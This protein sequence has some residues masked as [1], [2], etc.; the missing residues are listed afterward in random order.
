[1]EQRA[2]AALHHGKAMGNEAA[3]SVSARIVFP[4]GLVA[5]KPE[6]YFCDG[7]VAFAVEPGVKRAQGQNVKLPELR[8]HPAEIRTGRAAV[9][10]PPQSASGMCAQIEEAIRGQSEDVKSRFVEHCVRKPELMCHA[11][12]L[13]HAMP[14]IVGLSQIEIVEMRKRDNGFGLTVLVIGCR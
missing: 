1:M 4:I 5:A 3:D 12:D 10:R 6:Q 9:E 2:V 7:A 13:P 11:I 14:A 8:R